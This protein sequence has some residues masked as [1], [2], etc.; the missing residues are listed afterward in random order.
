MNIRKQLYKFLLSMTHLSGKKPSGRLAKAMEED[1]E[2]LRHWR[3][4]QA[5]TES[6]RS[7]TPE[8]VPVPP[9]LEKRIIARVDP[10]PAKVIPF[11]QSSNLGW[12]MS[13]VAAILVFGTM[14]MVLKNN[15]APGNYSPQIEEPAVPQISEHPGALITLESPIEN[16]PLVQLSA[17]FESPLRDEPQRLISDAENALRFLSRSFLPSEEW[18]EEVKERYFGS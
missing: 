14:I 1:P 11:W 5:L 4:E 3:G 9:S 12:Q 7:E 2:L 17:V 18:R 8:A 6:L 10:E 13:A 15:P 16:H